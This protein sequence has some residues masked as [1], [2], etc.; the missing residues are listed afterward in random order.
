MID[1]YKPRTATCTDAWQYACGEPL[2]E[3][4]KYEIVREYWFNGEGWLKVKNK[5]GKISE[6]AAADRYTMNNII[7]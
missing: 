6:P 1:D 5:A 3:N 2:I 7:K 4:Q